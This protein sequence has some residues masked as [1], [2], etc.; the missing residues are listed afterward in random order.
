MKTI[1]EVRDDLL[2]VIE[3]HR[4]ECG[5]PEC[6]EP[7]NYMAFLLHSA[8]IRVERLEEVKHYLQIYQA[9]CQG[10]QHLRN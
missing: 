2:Q 4:N 1:E 3:D 8:G 9:T 5:D 10:C 7:A 6:V